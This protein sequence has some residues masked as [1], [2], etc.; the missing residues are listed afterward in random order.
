MEE[1]L[2]VCP[3]CISDASTP[4]VTFSRCGHTFCQL[5][6][7]TYF[8]CTVKNG[9]SNLSCL[10]CSVAATESEVML[11]LQPD[12]YQKYLMLSLRRYLALQ[13][14]VRSCVAPDCPF[15]YLLENPSDC[16][17]DHFIC[18]NET[19]GIEFCYQCKKPWHEGMLCHTEARSEVGQ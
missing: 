4:F 13:S 15:I 7:Q 1:D 6:V 9:G 8:Q 3:V 19:C 12:T 17:D 11:Y 5:C 10:L 16:T 14:N 18:Q 2:A